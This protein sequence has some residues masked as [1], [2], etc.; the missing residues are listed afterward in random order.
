MRTYP[1]AHYFAPLRTARFYDL[2]QGTFFAALLFGGFAALAWCTIRLKQRPALPALLLGAVLC[3][4]LFFLG[5][6]GD[7]W[8]E[9][10]EVLRPSPVTQ[11]LQQDASLYRIYSL[12]RIES[13]LTYAHTPH[14]PFDRVYRVLTQS[15]PPNLHLYHRLASVDEYTELLNTRHYAIFGPVL[16]HLAAHS[17]NPA[18]N[19]YC[20]S[21]F[22]MLN[23]KYIISPRAL[24]ELQFELLHDGPVKLYRNQDVW[25]RAFMAEA[26]LACPDDAAVL[27]RI[28]A[29]KFEPHTVFVPEAELDKLPRQL[30]SAVMSESTG[31][32]SQAAVSVVR[33]EA[34]RVELQVETESHGLL[35]LS[36]TWFPGWIA[37]VNGSSSPVLRANHTLRAVALKPGSSRV[38]FAYRPRSFIAG[39]VMSVSVLLATIAALAAV[40]LRSSRQRTIKPERDKNDTP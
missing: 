21:I 1:V 34:N 16:Q 33:Y 40:W 17:D 13:G 27:E 4:D 9:R 2:Y 35:V 8:L 29:A 5:A 14:L 25:P 20:R 31:R 3:A 26:I 24:P 36:D 11:A 15:L 32:Y 12:A 10:Q 38:E 7:V 37:L 22:S 39:L 30:R 28:H 18:D 6:P 23:V 19:H